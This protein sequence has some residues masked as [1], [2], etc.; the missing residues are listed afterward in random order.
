ML[1]IGAI[2]KS[3]EPD[4]SAEERRELERMVAEAAMPRKKHHKGVRG[5]PPSSPP[6]I[7]TPKSEWAWE[8]G[9]HANQLP[10]NLDAYLDY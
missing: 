8:M 5:S 3:A 10:F 4:E 2:F 1:L 9:L 6:I 7:M